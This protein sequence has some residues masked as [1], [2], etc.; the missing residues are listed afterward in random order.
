MSKRLSTSE[1]ITPQC[2]ASSNRERF[3]APTLVQTWP[4]L[5]V[6]E[7]ATALILAWALAP[8][9]PQGILGR[10]RGSL[11][12]PGPLRGP[13]L[14]YVRLLP[15]CEDFVS[16]QLLLLA[17]WKTLLTAI[18]ST[19]PSLCCLHS[20][21]SRLRVGLVEASEAGSCSYLSEPYWNLGQKEKFFFFFFYN[22]DIL[23][24]VD[25]GINF[26]LLK[27]Y[28]KILVPP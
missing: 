12:V 4:R 11:G 2:R 18:S 14:L 5:A 19:T 17:G 28:I 3:M 24:I 27:Y 26:D 13:A 8:P 15:G 23:F 6:T 1:P 9:L 25:F 10:P 20:L 16:Y 21:Y 22:F 7:A